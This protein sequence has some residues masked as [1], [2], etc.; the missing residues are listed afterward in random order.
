MKTRKKTLRIAQVT[1]KHPSTRVG[2]SDVD[3]FTSK[4]TVGSRENLVVLTITM[5]FDA[6][7][8]CSLISRYGYWVVWRLHSS[9]ATE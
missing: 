6:T 7:R 5:A 8:R 1:S 9:A 4:A 2:D 3:A